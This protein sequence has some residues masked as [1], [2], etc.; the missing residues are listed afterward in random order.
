MFLEGH[1]WSLEPLSDG[2]T[3]AG[4]IVGFVVGAL[5]GGYLWG[6]LFWHF[7]AKP[8]DRDGPRKS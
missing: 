6:S 3:L 1:G 5:F 8:A 4:L 2:G 7:F